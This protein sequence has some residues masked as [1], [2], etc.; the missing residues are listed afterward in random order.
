MTTKQKKHEHLLDVL[1]KSQKNRIVVPSDIDNDRFDFTPVEIQ[2]MTAAAGIVWVGSCAICLHNV[3]VLFGLI[4]VW[5]IVLALKPKCTMPSDII[6]FTVDPAN[7]RHPDWEKIMDDKT[8]V[9]TSP[10]DNNI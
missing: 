3:W 2:G 7:N 4:P 9:G 10:E 6:H 5:L 1:E 8:D